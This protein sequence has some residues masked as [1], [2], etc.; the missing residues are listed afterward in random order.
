MNRAPLDWRLV[1][2]AVFV[3]SMSMAMF[4]TTYR[5]QQALHIHPIAWCD[6]LP[7]R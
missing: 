3:W 5:E 4:M 1:C 2:A 6:R 7:S